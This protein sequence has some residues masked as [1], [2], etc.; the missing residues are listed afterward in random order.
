MTGGLGNQL[1]IYALYRSLQEN[2][3]EVILDTSWYLYSDAPTAALYHLDKFQCK[4]NEYHV[5]R[6]IDRCRQSL[7]RN[8]YDDILIKAKLWKKYKEVMPGVFDKHVF[9]L[10]DC[11]L[12]GCWQSEKYFKDIAGLIRSE[13][14]YRGEYS[15]KNIEFISKIRSTNSV[16]LHVR[17]GDYLNFNMLY[18]GICTEDYY[19]RAIDYFRNR[20]RNITFFVFSDDIKWCKDVLLKDIENVIFIEGNEGTESYIDMLLMSQCK[21]HIIA[22]S[23]FSWWGAWLSGNSGITVSPTKW[24]NNSPTTDVWCND[25]VRL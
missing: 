5:P 13:L 1:F 17:R 6:I 22:N 15:E 21:N 19:C 4:V 25:W 20:E 7:T 2:G 11:Y 23:S 12:E 24:L 9:E 16:S 3:K 8:G 10:D 18:G 14:I